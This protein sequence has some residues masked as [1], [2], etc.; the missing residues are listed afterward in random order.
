MMYNSMELSVNWCQKWGK[1]IRMSK[2]GGGADFVG[3]RNGGLNL[4]ECSTFPCFNVHILI[5]YEHSFKICGVEITSYDEEALWLLFCCP[6]MPSCSLLTAKLE[7]ACRW[8]YTAATNT[9]VISLGWWT[10]LHFNSLDRSVSH[11]GTAPEPAFVNVYAHT[12]PVAFP[13]SL[14][15]L[16]RRLCSLLA[17]QLG[18]GCFC[19][20]RFPLS[21]WYSC[22]YGCQYYILL[23]HPSCLPA[24]WGWWERC[25][26]LLVYAELR[27]F[28]SW[29]YHHFLSAC[30]HWLIASVKEWIPSRIQQIRCFI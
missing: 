17:P 6:L 7:L 23:P 2:T 27:L 16:T 3:S 26:E 8:I 12:L 4:V 29:S 15:G 13:E 28:H 24:S 21:L 25:W 5:K 19:A 14:C 1:V 10:S 9:A 30:S 18:L 22:H 11:N 20:A